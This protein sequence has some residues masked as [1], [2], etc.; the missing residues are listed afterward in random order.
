M[1]QRGVLAFVIPV[2]QCHLALN[3]VH[4]DASNQGQQRTLALAQERIWWTMMAEDCCVI[5]RGC[6]HC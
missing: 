4:C 2:G 6:L 1:R 5:V 3:G